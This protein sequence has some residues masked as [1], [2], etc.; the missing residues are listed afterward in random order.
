MSK[1]HN[2]SLII[3]ISHDLFQPSAYKTYDG[4]FDLKILSTS[5]DTYSMQKAINYNVTVSNTGDAFYVNGRAA[6]L[7]KTQ[8]SRCLNDVE[9]NLHTNIESYFL[10]EQPQDGD[11]EQGSEFE[12]LPVDHNIDLGQIIVKSFLLNIPIKP[13]CKKDCKG[14]C[15]N[16]GQNLNEGACKCKIA[17]E[18]SSNPFSILK[19]FNIK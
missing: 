19:D 9:L 6:G 5:F 16:C 2:N 12:I 1:E 17:N 14:L 13:I 7:A 18:D 8:C 4:C 3:H 10:I 11:I 15:P